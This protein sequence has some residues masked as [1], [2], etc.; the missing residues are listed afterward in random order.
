MPLTALRPWR[1]LRLP[2]A[3]L[4][5]A[6]LG[7]AATAGAQEPFRPL[8]QGE[9]PPDFT[10]PDTGGRPV[11]LSDFKGRA[12]LLTFVSCYTDTCLAVLTDLEPLVLKLGPSR[13]A[14]LSVCV[15]VPAALRDGGYAGLLRRC[16]AGQTLL[17]DEQRTTSDRYHATE[18]PTSVL[19]APD[20]TVR[21]FLR[22]FPALRDPALRSRIEALA[23]KAQPASPAP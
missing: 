4:G 16:G 20:F 10:L 6:L 2:A 1:W 22:G 19:I 3:A 7:A 13:L 15:E 8:I 17:I 11:R 23:P 9:A 18:F 21:E 14:A 12:I 5:L